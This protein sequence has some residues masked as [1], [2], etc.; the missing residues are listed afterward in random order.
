MKDQY[1]QKIVDVKNLPRIIV[2]DSN[3]FRQLEKRIVFYD[4]TSVE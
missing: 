3:V 4:F 2:I 1:R